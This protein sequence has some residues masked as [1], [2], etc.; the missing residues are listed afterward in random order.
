MLVLCTTYQT[1]QEA[2]W[3]TALANANKL[4]MPVTGAA[5]PYTPGQVVGYYQ[6][7]GM[8]ASAYA[9]FKDYCE[10]YA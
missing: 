1:S 4:A 2:H 3:A 6:N 9:F 7:A 10:Q 5:F 8:R